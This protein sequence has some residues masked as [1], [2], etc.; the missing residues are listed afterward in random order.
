MGTKALTFT[1]PDLAYLRST[2]VS[3]DEICA[4]HAETPDDIRRLIREGKLPQPSYVLDDGTELVWPDYF[5]LIDAAGGADGLHDEYERQYRAAL[6]KYGLEF[7]RELMETRW[8]SYMEG[9]SGICLREV[10]PETGVRKRLLIDHIERLTS[11]PR[12]DDQ[13]WATELRGHVDELD[14]LEKQ[15]AP[16][17]DRARF[18][19]TRDTYI[20]DVRR[21]YPQIAR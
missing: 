19:P 13:Q 1:E 12:P 5:A 8:G 6:E 15:F 9:I 14:A 18:V 21:A 11:E 10:N 2:F 7:D 4:R 17:Y 20:N 3:L 16:N